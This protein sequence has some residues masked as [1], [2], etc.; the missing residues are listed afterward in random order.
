VCAARAGTSH[1]CVHSRLSESERER[2]S[3]R[4]ATVDKFQGGE[5]DVI[6]FSL[7]L[8]PTAP[9]STRTFLQKER[10][11]LNVAVSRAKALCII[12]GDLSYAKS[13][14][15]RHIE[16]LAERASR[17]WSPPKPNLFDSSW[18]R[19]LYTAMQARG[20]QPFPQY[21]VG[22]R[23]LDFALDPDGIMLDVEV[24]GRR[25]HTER[26]KLRRPQQTQRKCRL[27]ETVQYRNYVRR[28]RSEGNGAQR[29]K[30]SRPTGCA[31]IT[32][33]FC[34]K[35]ENIEIRRSCR[36]RKETCRAVHGDQSSGRPKA[37]S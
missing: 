1:E 30:S 13:C 18:E 33:V 28:K 7:V 34:F 8:T 4:I 37:S 31:K 11:R 5:A 16:F 2:L 22:R 35:R 27:S 6:I 21:P 12:V 29:Q 32:R 23:Y 10:R 25:W 36:P 14:R 26:T 24:D 9:L 19:R 17:P 15:V 3:L 20:L